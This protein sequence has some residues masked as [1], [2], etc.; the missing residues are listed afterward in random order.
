[1]QGFS[2]HLQSTEYVLMMKDFFALKEMSCIG[3][4]LNWCVA[5]KAFPHTA[6]PAAEDCNA[7]FFL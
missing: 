3:V 5:D 7:L 2:P 6:G 1:M 4:N